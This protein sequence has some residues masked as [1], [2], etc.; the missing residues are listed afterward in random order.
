LK[1]KPL[2][3]IK[4]AKGY[5]ALLILYFVIASYFNKQKMNKRYFALSA[6]EYRD[7]LYILSKAKEKQFEKLFGKFDSIWDKHEEAVEWLRNNAKF[8]DYC[9]CLT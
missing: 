6:L 7:E 9:T 2:T 8:V 1:G 4:R 5:I 3:I